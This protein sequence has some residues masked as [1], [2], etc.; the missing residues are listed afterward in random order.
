L[1]CGKNVS[2]CQCCE[3]RFLTIE[4]LGVFL[5]G[6]IV[7]HVLKTVFFYFCGLLKLVFETFA[8]VPIPAPTF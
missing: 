6:E 8:L 1:Y 7:I 3:N 4:H 2:E 5:I